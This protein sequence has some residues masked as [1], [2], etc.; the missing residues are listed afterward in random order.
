MI[1]QTQLNKLHKYLF[2]DAFFSGA[3]QQAEPEQSVEL[4]ETE[5]ENETETRV[6]VNWHHSIFIIRFIA[7]FIIELL[8]V[9]DNDKALKYMN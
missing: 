9:N 4:K 7:V 1:A 8:L 3:Q 5:L 6:M 2:N